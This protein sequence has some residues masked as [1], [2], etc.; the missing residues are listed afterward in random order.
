MR[1]S[2]RML[3]LT[4]RSRCSRSPIVISL[5]VQLPPIAPR[6]FATSTT[7]AHS[8]SGFQPSISSVFTPLDTF[9]PRHLGPRSHDVDDMLSVLGY[10]TLDEFVNETIPSGVRV[11][12]LA[13]NNDENGL[14]PLSELELRRRA[15]TIAGMNRRMKSYIGMGFVALDQGVGSMLTLFCRYHNAI[16]PPVI[17][18]NVSQCPLT[19]EGVNISVDLRESR[20]VYCIYSLLTRTIAGPPR[21]PDQFS[22][23]GHIPLRAAYCQCISS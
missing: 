18:R 1:Q 5:P 13:D 3:R 12:E 6:R 23:S 17:Q 21:V 22:N 14:R 8:P 9:L 4:S 20:L 16:V 2:S 7:P 10:K 15:E 19:R 11:A